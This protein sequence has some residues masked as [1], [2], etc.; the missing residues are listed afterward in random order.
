VHDLPCLQ[1]MTEIRR[2]ERGARI[3]LDKQDGDA[4]IP[5]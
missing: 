4:E 3:L 5:E 2:L 1:H